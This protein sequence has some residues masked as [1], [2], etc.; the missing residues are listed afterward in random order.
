MTGSKHNTPPINDTE[1]LHNDL[2]INEWHTAV[3]A[4]HIINN[5]YH[6]M[7]GAW[8]I[9]GMHMTSTPANNANSYINSTGGFSMDKLCFIQKL[10]H[11]FLN[12]FVCESNH[13]FF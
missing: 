10:R 2:M 8:T 7:T 9:F 6:S 12:I 3:A 11:D 4:T 1:N 13:F 5:L